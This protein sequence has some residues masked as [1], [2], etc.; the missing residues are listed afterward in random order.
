MANGHMKICST[1][2]I[3]REMKIKMRSS[4]KSERPSSKNLQT[5]NAGED[6]EKQLVSM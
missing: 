5:I 6:V 2:F 1:L 3:I 4:Q